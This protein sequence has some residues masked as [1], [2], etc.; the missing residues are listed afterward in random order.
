[1][2]FCV[3]YENA[4]FSSTH[5]LLS[6]FFNSQFSLFREWSFK[7]KDT[8][9]LPSGGTSGNFVPPSAMLSMIRPPL[10]KQGPKD[11]RETKSL[12]P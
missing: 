12:T 11:S 6:I 3:S 1:M 7:L 10:E 9:D 8:M 4:F 5:S 2:E